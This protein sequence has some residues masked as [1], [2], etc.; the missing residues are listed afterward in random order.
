MK[1]NVDLEAIRHGEGQFFLTIRRCAACGEPADA[2]QVV[3]TG[4]ARIYNDKEDDVEFQFNGHTD[5]PT[6]PGRIVNDDDGRVLVKCENG[7]LW[8]S[9]VKPVPKT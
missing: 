9:H 6:F 5:T 1:M 4:M 2:M 8:Y 7:H 3:M